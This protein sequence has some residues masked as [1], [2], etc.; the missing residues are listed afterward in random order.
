MNKTGTA[1]DPGK[2]HPDPITGAPGSHPVGT[3]LGAA[4]AGAIGAA[5]GA[6]GG[7]L[8]VAVGVAVGGVAGGYAGKSLARLFDPTAEEEFWREHHRKQ[9]Y[10]SSNQSYEDWEA[11][12]R[13]G[14]I[15]YQE[16]KK[17]EDCEAE[18]RMEYEGGSQEVSNVEPPQ[19][20]GDSIKHPGQKLPWEQA[21]RAARAAYERIASGQAGASSNPPNPSHR[22][23]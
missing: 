17:F 14:Y 13:T 12:Y 20:T 19:N 4:A 5:V 11:A 23:P 18:L 16:G 8:G 10:Y 1:N 6:V 22:Q 3:G 2:N 7:P 9:S 21:Q 15:G